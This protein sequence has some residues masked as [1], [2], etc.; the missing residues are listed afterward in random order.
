VFATWKRC[1]PLLAPLLSPADDSATTALGA[2]TV[3]A[4]FE[5]SR[6]L[7]REAGLRLALGVSK[8]E[9]T[10]ALLG[11]VAM[12]SPFGMNALCGV[13]SRATTTPKCYLL[14]TC[15]QAQPER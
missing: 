11:G 13:A 9:T 2:S 10:P 14:T 5:A 7:G 1:D 15:S 8:A 12:L 3:A 6:R 4:Q